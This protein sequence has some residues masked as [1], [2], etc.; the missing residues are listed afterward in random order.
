[1]KTKSLPQPNIND[2]HNPIAL[3]LSVD[4]HLLLEDTPTM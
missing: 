2:S 1:M 4:L 3:A